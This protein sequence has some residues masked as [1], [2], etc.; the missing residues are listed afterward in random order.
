MDE[1]RCDAKHGDWACMKWYGHSGPHLAVGGAFASGLMWH[2][3][4]EVV[5]ELAV[6]VS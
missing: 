5:A 2:S 4:G 1:L 6:A 3:D